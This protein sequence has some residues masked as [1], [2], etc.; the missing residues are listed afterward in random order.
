MRRVLHT[1]TD[2]A[3]VQSFASARWGDQRSYYADF[4][5]NDCCF[6]VGDPSLF[7]KRI[8]EFKSVTRPLEFGLGG[9]SCI[10]IQHRRQVDV[11]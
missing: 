4:P 10:G 2:K 6:H 1:G 8:T 5:W 3:L 11:T 7:T 9:R